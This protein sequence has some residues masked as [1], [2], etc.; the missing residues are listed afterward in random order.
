MAE[1][2]AVRNCYDNFRFKATV[3]S[4]HDQF[5]W[6]SKVI[7]TEYI[8]VSLSNSISVQIE[9]LR[10]TRVVSTL[11]QFGRQTAVN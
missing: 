10:A 2:K 1:R 3:E 11:D 5:P 4:F 6:I 8:V 9:L 7:F